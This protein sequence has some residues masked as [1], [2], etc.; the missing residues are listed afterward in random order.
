[1]SIYFILNYTFILSETS[2]PCFFTYASPWV[3]LPLDL[4]YEYWIEH[5]TFGLI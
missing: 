4:L 5:A 1:M 2:Y 3:F